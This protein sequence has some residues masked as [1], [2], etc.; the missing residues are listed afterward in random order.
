MPGLSICT[1][2]VPSG[3][4]CACNSCLSAAAIAAASAILRASSTTIE[5]SVCSLC[6]SQRLDVDDLLNTRNMSGGVMDFRADVR[7]D[8]IQA[9]RDDR[10]GRLPDNA[11]NRERDQK[12]DDGVGKRK[13]RP[14]AGRS[15]DNGQ[16]GEAIGAGV[17]AVGDER[18]AVHGFADA[19]A[20]HRDGFVADE[21]DDTRNGD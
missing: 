13:A 20:E 14:N 15:E 17:I 7:I 19:N 12:A 6:P 10:L 3:G 5:T 2:A 9:S 1:V 8:A 11:E 21:T 18:R 16:A 4:R